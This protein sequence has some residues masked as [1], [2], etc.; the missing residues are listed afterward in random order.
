MQVHSLNN[1][2]PPPHPQSQLIPPLSHPTL[3]LDP[4]PPH[5]S[6]ARN[7]EAG[8]HYYKLPLFEQTLLNECC[9][10]CISLRSSMNA[11]SYHYT[12]LNFL[13]LSLD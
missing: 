13:T 1:F 4:S 7:L 5:C 10:W 11:L 2:L 12:C 3:F 6:H 8:R 9:V